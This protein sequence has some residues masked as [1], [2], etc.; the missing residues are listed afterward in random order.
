[1]ALF[2]RTSTGRPVLSATPAR[3]GRTGTHLFWVLVFGTLLAALALFAAWTWYAPELA[4]T[5]SNNGP[6]PAQHFDAPEPV[7]QQAPPVESASPK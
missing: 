3:Q 1:M 7:A 2:T 5:N 4:S 6:S